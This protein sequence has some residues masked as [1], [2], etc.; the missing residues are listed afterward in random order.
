MLRVLKPTS[1]LSVGSFILAPFSTLAGAAAA[2]HVTGRLPRIG[3]VAGPGDG[4]LR[5]RSATDR[6]RGGSGS[7]RLRPTA[8]DVHRRT[9]RQHRGPGLARR[10]PRAPVR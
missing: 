5:P 1:P 3:R 2:S 8:G 6:A 7:R 10:A 9:P 4:A